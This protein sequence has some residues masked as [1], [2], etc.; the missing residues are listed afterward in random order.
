MD[1]VL[2]SGRMYV[3]AIDSKEQGVKELVIRRQQLK[4]RRIAHSVA[5]LLLEKMSEYRIWN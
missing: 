4:G 2:R 1:V 5:S 3:T